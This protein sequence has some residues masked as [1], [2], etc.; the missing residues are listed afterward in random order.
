VGTNP[1]GIAAPTNLGFPVVMDIAL[2]TAGKGMMQWQA[3]QGQPM[4]LDWALTPDGQ[5]TDDPTAAMAGALLGIGQYKGYGLAFMTDV[6]TG[7]VGGGGY[8]LT[9]YK[10]QAKLDVSHSLTAVDIEWFMPLPEFHARMADFAQ[11]VK[12]RALRPGFT[13]ILLPGEQ[14]ARRVT[15]KSANGVPLEDVALND[16]RALAQRNRDQIRDRR[17]RPLRGHTMSLAPLTPA[18]RA[19]I[20]D[21]LR[22]RAKTQA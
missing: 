21:R 19:M 4:P 16:L 2:T 7:I 1:W 13:E 12:S 3:R 10:D 22:A 6:L 15:R 11:M 17:H 14:E 8:G 9:P 5:E 18:F 20:R